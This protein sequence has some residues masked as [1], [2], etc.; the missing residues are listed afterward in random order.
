MELAPELLS[1]L[2]VDAEVAETDKR[3]DELL[4]VVLGHERAGGAQ[5]GHRGVGLFS[6]FVV[7]EGSIGQHTD[8]AWMLVD[9]GIVA[10]AAGGVVGEVEVVDPEDEGVEE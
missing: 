4:R 3:P 6:N 7:G 1:T 8:T 5:L 9:G 10:L 2:V